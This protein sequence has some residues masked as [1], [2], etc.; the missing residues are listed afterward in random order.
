MQLPGTVLHPGTVLQRRFEIL[1]VLGR[2][3]MGTVYLVNDQMLGRQLAIKEVPMGE[4][5]EDQEQFL[6]EARLLASLAHPNLVRV[7]DMFQEDDRLYLS[8]EYIEGE[9]LAHVIWRALR[10]D[11]FIPFPTVLGWIDT[12][13]D[14]LEYLHGLTP[15]VVYRDLKPGNALLDTRNK[16]WL[17]DMGI[18]RV[19]D[20]ERN[21]STMVALTP[22]YSPVEQ[23]TKGNSGPWMDIYALGATL[24]HL[25]TKEVPP[26][27][28]DRMLGTAELLP[29]SERNPAISRAL[30]GVILKMMALQKEDRYQNVAEA[31]RAL[32]D[33]AARPFSDPAP[34]VKRSKTTTHGL[35][36]GEML[37]ERYR[38]DSIVD[39]GTK[40]GLYVGHEEKKPEL[41]LAIYEL[42][43]PGEGTARNRFLDRTLDRVSTLSRVKSP[44]L[45]AIA[46]FVET[47]GAGYLIAEWVDG[48][49]LADLVA[50]LDEYMPV[51]QA[52]NVLRTLCEVVLKL[53]R[54]KPQ[55]VFGELTPRHVQ[56]LED[57][58]V[59]LTGFA[60]G[61]IEDTAYV[62]RY[63]SGPSNDVATDVYGLGAVMYT[64]LTR[65]VPPSLMDITAGVDSLTPPRDL[66]PAVSK[67]LNALVMR[68]MEGEM[69]LEDLIAALGAPSADY[70][71]PRVRVARTRPA[72]PPPPPPPP[73]PP[74][75]TTTARKRARNAAAP[76]R[77]QREREAF[78]PMAD[79]LGMSFPPPTLCIPA[80]VWW[81]EERGL[82]SGLLGSSKA[83]DVSEE[84]EVYDIEVH[85]LRFTSQKQRRSNTP[86]RIVLKVQKW[87]QKPAKLDLRAKVSACDDMVPG[88]WSYTV[89]LHSLPDDLH[90][91]LRGLGP[92][93]RSTPRQARACEVASP[94]L[95]G[96][97]TW[98]DDISLSGMRLR[99]TS[100]LEPGHKMGIALSLGDAVVKV[101]ARVVYCRPNTDGFLSG[102]SFEAIQK[103]GAEVLTRYLS[104]P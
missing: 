24:Y 44:S 97:R 60:M 69:R 65:R 9:S 2:G 71:A 49:L 17:V 50:G 25:V 1:K 29:P 68:L 13:C 67:E 5:E 27:S 3:G 23:Y 89:D 94:S 4:D 66:N 28:V 96:G 38:I 78:V 85:S 93:R 74:R 19:M 90:E 54:A 104:S 41:Q 59:K 83:P 16:L 64:M 86:L 42:V 58:S 33:A 12:I 7:F 101:H 45:L 70:Q 20:R 40:W 63:V 55:V 22:G 87:G 103:S 10:R 57:S 26:A 39:M 92:D 31:R 11:E 47:P 80:T 82:L 30:D 6:R 43:L 91:V 95:P 34:A 73:A 53:H 46:D 51:E 35:N 100:P 76:A 102:I 88:L 15:P 48:V 32:H 81:P 36:P 18:A 79:V 52:T 98:C 14:V 99:T 77:T 21:T 62:D 37:E 8:M 61:K 56:V 72:P 84:V 75:T